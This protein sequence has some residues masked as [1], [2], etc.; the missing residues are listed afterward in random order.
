MDTDSWKDKEPKDWNFV[1]V[2][3][4]QEQFRKGYSLKAVFDFEYNENPLPD[5]EQLAGFSP[6]VAFYGSPANSIHSTSSSDG[7]TKTPQSKLP[8]TDEDYSFYDSLPAPTWDYIP[9][10]SNLDTTVK[11]VFRFLYLR[12]KIYSH[13]NLIIQS[14]LEQIIQYVHQ[15]SNA[16]TTQ[17]S[18]DIKENISASLLN[19]PGACLP[20]GYITCI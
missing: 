10:S 14:E 15:Y 2:Y 9:E 3:S 20:L 18:N 16:V 17:S 4:W 1:D 19:L 5:G 12:K 8:K 6:P 11:S 13:V 7:S